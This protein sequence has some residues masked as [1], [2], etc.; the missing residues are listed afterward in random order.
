MNDLDY[1]TQNNYIK[2]PFKD[3]VSLNGLTDDFFLDAQVILLDSSIRAYLSHIS[4]DG[5]ALTIIIKGTNLTGID[6]NTYTLTKDVN[7][8]LE[9]DFIAWQNTNYRIKLVVG[10]GLINAITN[11][12]FSYDLTLAQGEFTPSCIISRPPSVKSLVLNNLISTSENPNVVTLAKGYSA[13]DEVSLQEGYNLDFTKGDNGLALKIIPNAGDGLYD[14][15]ISS[16]NDVVK[17]I[18]NILPTIN[19]NF[20]IF[21]DDCYSSNPSHTVNTTTVY[22]PVNPPEFYFTGRPAEDFAGSYGEFHP[23]VFVGVGGD[24]N[25]NDYKWELYMLFDHPKA[26][27]LITIY[28]SDVNGVLQGTEHWSTGD[29]NTVTLNPSFGL[30]VFHNNAQL[31]S[32][33]SN[34]LGT[35]TGLTHFTLYGQPRIS[36]N[37]YFT[38]KI[39]YQDDTFELKITTAQVQTPKP[40]DNTTLHTETNVENGIRFKH[41]CSPKCTETQVQAFAY[42]LNRVKDGL[43]TIN[44]YANTINSTLTAATDAYRNNIAVKSYK[45]APYIGVEHTITTSGIKW[46]VAF[47]VGIIDPRK[48][49]LRSTLLVNFDPRFTYESK[50]STLSADNVL[51]TLPDEPGFIDKVLACKSAVQHEFVLNVP[52][53]TNSIDNTNL[54]T[55]FELRHMQGTAYKTLPILMTVPYFS[56][57]YTNLRGSQSDT[58]PYTGFKLAIIVDMFDPQNRLLNT[59]LNIG[60]PSD[61]TYVA[62]TAKLNLNNTITSLSGPNLPTTNVN[63]S[64]KASLS[65]LARRSAVSTVLR[66]MTVTMNTPSDSFSKTIPINFYQTAYA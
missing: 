17:K 34:N 47:A 28:Q 14:G 44:N 61:V 59:T 65:F 48:E 42:Y 23:G 24:G 60:L 51:T 57:R 15:C 50:T 18:N 8:V 11:G 22:T 20:R 19:G 38:V 2:F 21:T 32:A 45:R 13:G 7:L 56:V 4:T 49:D 55:S 63:F 52:I 3:N 54:D 12:P 5:T 37:T 66:N 41:T 64:H 27:K 10:A 40:T 26:I 9:R 33:Y 43:L 62:D 1:L 58:V 29:P 30:V 35:F 53:T 39:V 46:F 31:N 25:P 36:V 16:I 6:L